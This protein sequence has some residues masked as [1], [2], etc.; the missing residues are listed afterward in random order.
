MVK[1]E[2]MSPSKQAADQDEHV[3]TA[4]EVAQQRADAL[5]KRS[6]E[7]IAKEDQMKERQSDSV[8][9]SAPADQPAE[10]G[11]AAEYLDHLQRLQAEFVNYR[12]RVERERAEYVKYANSNL[13]LDLTE[14]LDDFE[15]G[16]HED[17]LAEV[18]EPFLKGIEGVLRKFRDLLERQGLER[19]EA[20]GEAFDPEI[21]E[22]AMQETTD[23]YEP[24]TVSGEIRPGYRLGDR[25]LRPPLVKVAAAP[26]KE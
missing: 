18:P 4:W 7:E 9:E 21:H 19:I 26:A 11:K 20:I 8:S 3:K 15:R 10:A 2:E 1:K 5:L 12:R 6:E 16:L 23:A 13:I 24:G 25:L 22:A 17:H 14:V